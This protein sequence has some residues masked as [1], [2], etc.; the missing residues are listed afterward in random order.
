MVFVLYSATLVEEAWE[1]GED[2]VGAALDI[3]AK[4]TGE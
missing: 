3:P 2:F 4:P 1:H